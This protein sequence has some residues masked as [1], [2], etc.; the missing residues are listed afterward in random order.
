MF[1]VT[2]FRTHWEGCITQGSPF[3]KERKNIVYPGF[4]FH[5]Y[6]CVCKEKERLFPLSHTTL[7]LE[8]NVHEKALVNPREIIR[9]NYHLA[10]KL[11]FNKLAFSTER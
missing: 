9:G 6:E 11:T 8:V 4:Y 1:P 7:T 2:F 10:L 5:L 3:D